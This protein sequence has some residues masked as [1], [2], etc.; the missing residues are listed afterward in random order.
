[1]NGSALHQSAGVSPA[2][3]RCLSA[4]LEGE[5]MSGEVLFDVM[6]CDGFGKPAMKLLLIALADRADESGVCW[7]SRDD[8]VLRTGMSLSTITRTARA[9]EA[10]QWVQRKQRRDTSTVY[11][12]NVRKIARCAEQCKAARKLRRVVGD[13]EPFPEELAQGIEKAGEGQNEPGS[14][15]SEPGSG[16]S[17]P[18]SGHSDRLT[19]QEPLKEP[20]GPAALSID[21]E[22]V[23]RI[24]RREILADR[25][26]AV[27]GVVLKPGSPQ[28]VAISDL[29][30][31]GASE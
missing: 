22:K 12:L 16:H 9:L 2:P 17:E 3:A 28:F 27:G 5:D 8:L 19:S 23:G 30:R 15:H 21:L 20:L 13:W 11:R 29:L 7:P 1:L 25:S 31:K 26:A 6:N 18:G 14:G 4:S 10:G 24:A